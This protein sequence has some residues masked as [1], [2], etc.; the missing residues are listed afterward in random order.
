MIYNRTA[1][2]SNGFAKRL[3]DA[4]CEAYHTGL[5]VYL[6]NRRGARWLRV[7][8]VELTPNRYSFDFWANNGQEVGHLVL[9]GSFMWSHEFATRF[10]KITAHVWGLPKH[11]YQIAKERKEL[12]EWEAQRAQ[13]L[14]EERHR[15]KVYERAQK[16]AKVRKVRQIQAERL[17]EG[18]THHVPGFGYGFWRKGFLW[19]IFVVLELDP[20]FV[21]DTR[22]GEKV[23]EEYRWVAK[24]KGVAI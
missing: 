23:H 15:L 10:A 2:T 6:E 5:P 11:P 21:F 8:I 16:I 4:M 22:R 1:F 12:A 20:R 19:D 14:E 9:Q 24:H 7:R 13:R 17:A 3:C 18:I